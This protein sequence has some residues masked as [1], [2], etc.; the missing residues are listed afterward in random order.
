M[1][2]EFKAAVLF[3]Q[4][5]PK[6]IN[7]EPLLL[8]SSRSA[9]VKAAERSTPLAEENEWTWSATP[10][11]WAAQE[12]DQSKS[13]T[14]LKYTLFLFSVVCFTNRLTICQLSFVLKRDFFRLRWGD[15]KKTDF[16]R[17]TSQFYAS[18]LMWIL[19]NIFDSF[20]YITCKLILMSPPIFMLM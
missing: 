16:A 15:L 20:W 12:P 19:W 6:W 1:Q 13:Y 3:L 9:R 17:K 8:V 10:G 2:L 11:G 4:W 7:V 18:P 14:A 5:M